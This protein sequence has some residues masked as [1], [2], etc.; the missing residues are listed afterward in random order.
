MKTKLKKQKI[1][2]SELRSEYESTVLAYVKPNSNYCS[3]SEWCKNK[4]IIIPK[5]VSKK[6]DEN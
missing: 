3:F 4:G 6:Y 1:N 5:K 2:I